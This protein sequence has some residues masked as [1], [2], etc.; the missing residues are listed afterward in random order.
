M[1]ENKITEFVRRPKE[2]IIY[3]DNR[4][5]Q[6]WELFMTII[7]LISCF[8]TPVEIA[9]SPTVD[10]KSSAQ[11]IFEYVMDFLFFS[12]VIVTFYCAYQNEDF[13][14]IDDRKVIAKQYLSGW[15]TVDILACIPFGVIGTL[16][17]SENRS[18]A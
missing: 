7:L 17:T 6:I 16:F 1:L 3:P 5:Y 10:S 15:F 9:F 8:L 4:M 12:D 18:K 2:N 13:T 14:I 11:S